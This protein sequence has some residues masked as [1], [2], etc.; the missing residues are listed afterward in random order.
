MLLA[1][2]GLREAGVESGPRVAGCDRP[3][4]SPRRPLKPVPPLRPG[5]DVPRKEAA[6]KKG[7]ATGRGWRR[8]EGARETGG[9]CAPSGAGPSP[10]AEG[11][12]SRRHGQCTALPPAG[13]AEAVAIA[14]AS[15]PSSPRTLRL[16]VGTE[17][18]GVRPFCSPDD[19]DECFS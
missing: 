14:R 11:R 9:G 10:A 2:R 8:E 1:C 12:T 6:P 13:T 7:T 18:E 17:R 4:P 16:D 15:S 3:A 19:N 5:R